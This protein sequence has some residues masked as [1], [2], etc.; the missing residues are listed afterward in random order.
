MLCFHV[1]CN[2]DDNYENVS[3][4][5]DIG[6]NNVNN[7]N[8]N[9]IDNHT[10]NNIDNNTNDDDNDNDD[11]YDHS[12]APQG[13]LIAI[14]KVLVAMAD[15]LYHTATTFCTCSKNRNYIKNILFQ[16]KSKLITTL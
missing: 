3:D 5:I 6:I 16:N 7:D 4:D 13:A 9:D 12:S 2:S 1:E 10:D 11:D 14:L 8:D 15:G